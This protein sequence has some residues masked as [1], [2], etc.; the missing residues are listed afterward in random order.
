MKALA[1]MDVNRGMG[2][3]GKLPWPPIKE[4]FRWFKQKTLE[5]KKLVMGRDT[6]QFVGP[7]KDRFTYVLTAD[8][9]LLAVPPFATYRYVSAD[10]FKPEPHDDMWLCGGAKTYTLLLPLCTEVY[11]T[12]VLGEY[13]V[14]TYMPPFE[15][16]FQNQEII[17]ESKE[18]WIVK[19]SKATV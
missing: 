15:D 12:H 18:F 3:H 7:L 19:Y 8:S 16:M 17:F 13:D 10:F 4:D 1:A 5:T 9:K 11:V 14:D 6:F 2:F